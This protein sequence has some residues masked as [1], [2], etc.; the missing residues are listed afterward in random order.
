MSKMIYLIYFLFLLLS[1]VNCKNDDI[2][3]IPKSEETQTTE[4]PSD[5]TVSLTIDIKNKEWVISEFLTGSHFVYAYE[6]DNIY[7]DYRIVDWMKESKVKIIRWPGGTAVQN[8]HWNDLNGIPFDCDTWDPNYSEEDKEKEPEVYMDLDEFIAFCK[9]VGAEPMVGVNIKSGKLYNR[10]EEAKQEAKALIEHCKSNNYNVKYW[11][12]GNEG[13]A[14]GF[15]AQ[16]YAKYIDTYAQILKEVD[17]NITIIGDWKFGPEDKNRFNELITVVS[18]S[19]H[20]DII[21]VHEK[22]AEGWGLYSGTTMSEWQ[23]EKQLF[24]GKLT[25][26]SEEFYKKMNEIGKDV[27]LA[28]NEWGLGSIKG[29]SD[30]ENGLVVADYMME[31]FRN[32]ICMA[33]YWNLNIGP[34]S[35]RILKVSN[36]YT[37]YASLNGIS[38]ISN[39][40]RLFSNALGKN[41]IKFEF[42]VEGVYGFA[43][44]NDNNIVQLYLL[45]KLDKNIKVNLNI[46]DFSINNISQRI[47]SE[48]GL[49]TESQK[50][51]KDGEASIIVP[52][53]S[54]S[55]YVLE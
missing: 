21:E 41:L 36:Y 40:F 32:R 12:I 50:E 20:I 42:P 3:N 5:S 8:Y 51:I 25:Y 43:T 10:E 4:L 49:I 52:S 23:K 26:Y 46:S 7:K 29:A 18:N 13:Y 14:S 22:W 31:I 19:K 44:I 28:M 1:L 30:F 15:G 45:N 24:N 53:M 6:S 33:C 16:L 48:P 34:G 2:L 9:K 17:P 39:V 11:Y 47:Y 35:S 38:V 27:K 37:K 54:L 55:Y